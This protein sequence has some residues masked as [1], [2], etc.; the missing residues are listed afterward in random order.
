MEMETKVETEEEDITISPE[1]K[2]LEPSSKD[3]S[4][5]NTTEEEQPKEELLNWSMV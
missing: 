5:L 2:F 1:V 4:L 3:V